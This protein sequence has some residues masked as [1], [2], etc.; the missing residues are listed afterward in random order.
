MTLMGL[1]GFVLFLVGFPPLCACNF[2]SVA[3]KNQSC[4]EL[5]TAITSISQFTFTCLLLSQ[6]LH[7]GPVYSA[8]F[9]ESISGTPNS[10]GVGQEGYQVLV[11]PWAFS[12][13]H[14]PDLT[15]C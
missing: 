2:H 7:K 10:T 4:E 15:R 8:E 9:S 14:H 12:C 5:H 3:E 1:V 13:N 11:S 6:L